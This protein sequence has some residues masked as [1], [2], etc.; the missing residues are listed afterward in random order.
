MIAISGTAPVGDDGRTVGSGDLTTQ[1]R[2]CFD[3][4][5][6]AVA[7]AGGSPLDVIRTRIMLVDIAMWKVAAEVHREYFGDHPPACTFV[8]ISGF[9]DPEWLV[10]IEVDCVLTSTADT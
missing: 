7:E 8:Q 9:I 6:R 5:M 10:E 1:L 4:A 2:A 3:R